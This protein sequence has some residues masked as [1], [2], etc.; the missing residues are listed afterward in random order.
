M[1][2]DEKN[3]MKKTRL[4]SKEVSRWM[5]SSSY[6]ISLS[7]KDKAELVE[8]DYKMIAINDLLSFF[9]YNNHWIPTLQKLQEEPHLL[10]Q[11]TVDM[12]AVKFVING[13][14]I[15]R[16][17]ITEIEEGIEK[18][19]PIVIIDLNNK[20]PLAVGIA[21]FATKE[22]QEMTSGKVIQNI[23]YVGDE[24]WNLGK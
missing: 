15:M 12:G 1:D 3:K 4:K 5:E 7:K 9:S 8:G 10:K 22:M 6:P 24:L 23:H 11:I 19:Q 20:R 2:W 17:G 18:E 21:L 16:P 13:A 14:D